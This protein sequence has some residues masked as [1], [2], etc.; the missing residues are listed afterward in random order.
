MDLGIAG[1]IAV[2]TGSTRGI[3]RA[4][5]QALAEEGCRVVTWGRTLDAAQAA[6]DEIAARGGTAM[7]VAAPVQERAAVERAIAAVIERFGH[8]DIL[9][10]N[11]G[12]SGDAPITRMTDEQWR[13]ILELNLDG[14]FYSTRAVV[15]G[16]IERRYGRIVNIASRAHF[17]EINKANYAAAKGGVVSFTRSLALELGEHGITVNAVAPGMIV[18]E[19][20]Q[21]L[22]QFPEVSR[23]ALERTPVGRLGTPRE[24]ADG[25]LYLVGASAGFCTGH[26]LYITGGRY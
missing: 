18:T 1:Q 24:I 16:M 7:A 26:T 14:V 11:A 25:V 2:V 6:A 21:G 9:V 22:P 10:N 4:I 15:P 8:I 3:G 23:R 19:R 5:A 20:L 13:S 12:F 17:G